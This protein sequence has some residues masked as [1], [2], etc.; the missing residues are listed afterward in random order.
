MDWRVLDG[1]HHGLLPEGTFANIDCE[2]ALT[3]QGRDGGK[4]MAVWTCTPTQFVDC[5]RAAL[6]KCRSDT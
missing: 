4:E 5:L 1:S 6:T 3:T 2:E